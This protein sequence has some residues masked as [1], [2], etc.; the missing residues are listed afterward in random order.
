MINAL[1]R[2]FS[3]SVKLPAEGGWNISPGSCACIVMVNASTTHSLILQISESL[4][5]LAKCVFC[6]DATFWQN[7]KRFSYSFFLWFVFIKK[8]LLRVK[9]MT[10]WVF[11]FG[12]SGTRWGL[13][14]TPVSGQT[15]PSLELPQTHLQKTRH[16]IVWLLH[17]QGHLPPPTFRAPPFCCLL[18]LHVSW[19]PLPSR[20][21][22]TF[23]RQFVIHGSKNWY[24]GTKHTDTTFEG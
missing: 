14:I 18:G 5:H 17:H 2:L 22:L 24:P 1:I 4:D 20:L 23:I 19:T 13:S 9:S 11:F 3:V 7:I 8:V 12:H 15:A 16:E 6:R 21:P 10:K